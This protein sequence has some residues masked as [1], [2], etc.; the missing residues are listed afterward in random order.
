MKKR[1]DPARQR[2]RRSGEGRR[3]RINEFVD[4]AGIEEVLGAIARLPVDL[5]WELMA[6]NII[7]L[8]PRRR[9]M[10]AAAEPLS[11][12]LP[13]GIMTGFGVDAGPAFLHV[14]R[15]TLAAWGVDLGE[16][17]ARALGNVRL[18]SGRCRPRDVMRD[19]IAGVPVRVLQSGEGI[20]SALLLVGDELVR[21]LGG[22]DQWLIAPMR[23]L[24]VSIGG[25]ADPGFVAWLNDELAGL[26]PNALAVEP[27]LLADGQLRLVPI[28]RAA[29]GL[30]AVMGTS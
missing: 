30:E 4:Q 22:A 3:V 23:D 28:E 25:D 17:T 1:R 2:H 29:A 5:D 7:P 16:V 27:F 26:D 19:A 10:P 18:R 24:L 21:I 8:L 15:E 9:P 13:P 11:V 14:G 12:L 6:P 20:A